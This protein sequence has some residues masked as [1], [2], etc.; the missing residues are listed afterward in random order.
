M[1]QV[2]IFKTGV[3][4]ASEAEAVINALLRCF[5]HYLI[6]FDLDDCDNILRVETGYG[7][8]D[9][10]Q[11]RQLMTELGYECFWL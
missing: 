1:K 8:I 2:E 6:N 7:H 11:V 5:P 9:E 4:K 3:C 10:K